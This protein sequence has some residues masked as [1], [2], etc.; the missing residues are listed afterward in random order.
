LARPPLLSLDSIALTF[1]GQPLLES[2]NLQVFPQDR[3]CLVGRNGS[4]KSTFLKIAAGRVEPDA[5]ERFVKPGTTWRYLEQ[6][7]DMSGYESLEDY[8]RDGLTGADSDARVPYLLDALGVNAQAD[9]NTASGGERRRAAIAR[10]LAP[11]PDILFLDEPTNHLDLPT[12]DWLESE[13]ARS[14]AALVLISH[15]R[16]FL[17]ATTRRTVWLDRGETRELD[18][19]FAQFEDWRDETLAQEELDRHKLARK[20]V[21]EEHWVTHGVSG[22]RKRN[23]RRMGELSD[24]KTQ[25]REARGPQGTSRLSVT[26]GKASGKRVVELFDVSKAYGGR[27]LVESLSLKIARGDRLAIIGP[28]G[29]GKTTLIKLLIGEIESDSGRIESGANIEPLIVDQ[30]RDSLAGNVTLGDALTGGAT[31]GVEVGGQTRHV[32]A[33][34]KDFLFLPEQR[35]TV[36][37]KLSGGE[38][39]RV[40][41][42]RGLRSPSNLLVLDEP[43]NDLDLETLDLLQE[44]VADYAGTVI[45]VSHDRD[46]ID[47]TATQTLAWE[48]DGQ[49]TLYAGGYSDMVAQRGHGV[50]KAQTENVKSKA[51]EPR[52][53][54]AKPSNAKL[55]YKHQ[56][57]LE[58]LPKEMEVMSAK[59]AKLDATLGQADYFTRDPDGFARDAKALETARAELDAME[60]EWLELEEMKDALN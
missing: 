24:L 7:P 26:E 38:R 56:H 60:M 1:G 47:R 30:S 40:Q 35:R 25:L 4:G 54:K 55:S 27:T 21:R 2:A 46:F 49:W 45:L 33:Y 22:R 13:L 59:I 32:I 20:I 19:N 5:G 10:A 23:M 17:E 43:T 36:L 50:R 8:V 3:A 12:I 18:Q 42:A 57:R 44:L 34:M 14:S 16:R 11:E 28:N 15:D 52:A 31:D 6:D 58:T 37:S 48:A 9:P 39:A 29:A 51:S 53:K 41:L